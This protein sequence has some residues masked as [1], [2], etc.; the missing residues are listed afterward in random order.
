MSLRPS[1]V[2]ILDSLVTAVHDDTTVPS[3]QRLSL[4]LVST[5]TFSAGIC[6]RQILRYINVYYGCFIVVNQEQDRD[7][8]SGYK[9]SHSKQQ[10]SA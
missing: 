8:R 5:L 4:R 7:D 6:V 9:D 2:T 10:D 1:T 3:C